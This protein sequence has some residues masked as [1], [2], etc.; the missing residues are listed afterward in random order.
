[1]GMLHIGDEIRPRDDLGSSLA[2]NPPFLQNNHQRL[3]FDN[4][5]GGIGGGGLTPFLLEW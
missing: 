5:S 2:E 4:E 3:E 1:M